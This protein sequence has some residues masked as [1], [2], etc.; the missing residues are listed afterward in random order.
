[1]LSL[2]EY[3]SK[4]R[5]LLDHLD[6]RVGMFMVH[7]VPVKSKMLLQNWI[8]PKANRVLAEEQLGDGWRQ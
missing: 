4:L 6:D 3:P 5:I 1:M 8:G 7:F 2:N